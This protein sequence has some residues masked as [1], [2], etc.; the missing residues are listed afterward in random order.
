MRVRMK[1]QNTGNGNKWRRAKEGRREGQDAEGVVPNK[2]NNNARIRNP[3]V[4]VCIGGG[5]VSTEVPGRTR[6]SRAD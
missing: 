3:N 5:S 4:Y 2:P 6:K 1:K